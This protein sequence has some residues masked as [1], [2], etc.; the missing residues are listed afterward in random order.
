MH[1]IQPST[2]TTTAILGEN[3]QNVS[4]SDE[5]NTFTSRL[6]QHQPDCRIPTNA[7]HLRNF[8]FRDFHPISSHT[9]PLLVR[10]ILNARD[11]FSFAE[12]AEI[13]FNNRSAFARSFLSNKGY[14]EDDTLVCPKTLHC[15]GIEL[16]QLPPNFLVKG[17]LILEYCPMLVTLPNNLKVQGSISV[18]NCESFLNIN[19]TIQAADN[20]K[21]SDC[22]HFER[23]NLPENSQINGCI[24][25]QNNSNF[26]DIGMLP[27]QTTLIIEGDNKLNF[28]NKDL[29]NTFQKIQNPI[30]FLNTQHRSDQCPSTHPNAGARVFTVQTR[31]DWSTVSDDTTESQN[32]NHHAFKTFKDAVTFWNTLST[33]LWPIIVDKFEAS[34]QN[35]LRVYLSLLLQSAEF[36]Q[37]SNITI[38]AN[39]LRN[40]LVFLAYK[41]SQQDE[42][43]ESLNYANQGCS[44]RALQSLSQLEITIQTLQA[45]ESSKPREK[46]YQLALGLIKLEVV[47]HQAF[48]HINISGSHETAELL[49]AFE[50]Q[51]KHA[52]HLPIA[53]NKMKYSYLAQIPKT[54]LE[55][56]IEAA[57]A[58]AENK[59]LVNNFLANWQPWQALLR[60]EASCAVN[61]QTLPPYLIAD[62]NDEICLLSMNKLST[63]KQAVKVQDQPGTFDLKL[64]LQWWTA[65]GTHPVSKQ[66]FSLEKIQRVHDKAQQ[67]RL[68]SLRSSRT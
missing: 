28:S 26:Y 11:I 33:E 67:V 55:K 30:F 49:L 56:T 47:H 1:S 10:W 63:V 7:N 36:N 32:S 21:V 39:R 25:L 64:L 8:F 34:H 57:K 52:L 59:T 65:H 6:S 58:A 17:N 27:I 51:L 12:E 35:I 23:L 46:L 42:I 48:A 61:W 43:I 16:M 15:K 24:H 37:I 53:N 31:S 22:D 50:T 19:S 5:L 40:A 4:S 54:V 29:F 14:Q 38:F 60:Y 44:D 13:E 68:A 9:P 41:T 20:I 62:K 18:L 66:P 45:Q 2:G 3:P